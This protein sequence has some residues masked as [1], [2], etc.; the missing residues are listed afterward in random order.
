MR[1]IIDVI[2]RKNYILE[3]HL[4]NNHMIICDMKT[5]LEGIRFRGLKDTLL[6]EQYQ[7]HNGDTIR[8]S[9]TCELTLDEIM[10]MLEY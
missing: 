1:K 3:I 9:E 5:R 6:F 7:I 10:L 8:W 2:P 4:N